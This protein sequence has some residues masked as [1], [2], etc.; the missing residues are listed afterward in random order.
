MSPDPLLAQM[1]GKNTMMIRLTSKLLQC[2]VL[3]GCLMLVLPLSVILQET[4]GRNVT[5]S[6]MIHPCSSALTPSGTHQTGKRPDGSCPLMELRAGL[7][8]LSIKSSSKVAFSASATIVAATND[9][10]IPIQ[11][12]KETRSPVCPSG[13]DLSVL[14]VLRI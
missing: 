2:V 7:A 13:P 6:T 4:E 1:K 8:L 11:P 9:R 3:F 5:R 10:P 14:K 12:Q